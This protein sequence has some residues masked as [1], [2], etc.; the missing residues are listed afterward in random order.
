MDTDI[1]LYG[2]E[3]ALP[4]DMRHEW[5]TWVDFIPKDKETVLLLN[6]NEDMTVK[7]DLSDG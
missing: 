4:P 6:D 7:G 1:I 2:F 3:L 5:S